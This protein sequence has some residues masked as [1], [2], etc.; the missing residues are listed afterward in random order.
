MPNVNET[1]FNKILGLIRE[2]NINVD[3]STIRE[4]LQLIDEHYTIKNRDKKADYNSSYYQAHKE[5][6]L[7][8]LKTKTHCDI[9]DCAI[10]AS[11]QH[12]H[13]NTTKHLRNM[14]IHTLRTA[15]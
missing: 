14:E 1:K 15:N 9:C 5:Q 12:I 13:N 7:A 6:T 11:T 2:H 3:E 10:N 8:K 4:I